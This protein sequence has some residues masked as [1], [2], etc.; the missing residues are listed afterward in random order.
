MNA[1]AGTADSDPTWAETLARF[2]RSAYEDTV[3]DEVLERSALQVLDTLAS[4]AGAYDAA[5]V[6]AARGAIRPRNDGPATLWF[7]DERADTL[8]ALLVNAAA[9]RF[10]D[11]N[12]VFLGSLGP[13]GH[14]SDNI[15]VAWAFAEDARASGRDLLV[16]IALSYEL[17]WRLRNHVFR[18]LPDGSK[19]D[20]STINGLVSATIAALLLG[21][22]DRQLAEAI[23][24]G[25]VRGFMLREV[26]GG[27]ISMT[28]AVASGLVAR[29]GGV[30]AR[31]AV[32]GMT[33]PALVFEGRRGLVRT[34][35]GEPDVAMLDALCAPPQWAILDISVKPRPALG[36][37][38]AVLQAAADL[39]ARRPLVAED[40]AEVIVHV[41]DTTW[42]HKHRE[43]AERSWPD[44]RESADHCIEFLVAVALLEGEVRPEHYERE[45]WRDEGVRAVMRRVRLAPDAELT[46]IATTSFPSVLEMVLHDG[47]VE[48]ERM[49][50]PPGSPGRPWGRDELVGKFAGLDRTGRDRAAIGRI[51]DEAMELRS[52]TSLDT[53]AGLLVGT[54]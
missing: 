30:A 10:L 22:D 40:V 27:E 17:V 39:V 53:L 49:V 36:T 38:Q 6:E 52:A 44:S 7:R 28:K 19:W 46:A 37:S 54:G 20:A 4:A 1:R 41:P 43:I 47:S 9:T 31:L 32:A 51:A 29:E 25:A 23:R 3:P 45:L 35:G 34:L 12:D 21:A 24:L 50:E 13:G 26:R 48:I 11:V 15:P 8:D 14:P 16:A 33:G 18:V 42:T 5:P 2:A